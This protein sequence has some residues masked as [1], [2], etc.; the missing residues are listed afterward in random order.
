[1][2][3]IS[4]KAEANRSSAVSLLTRSGYFLREVF[5]VLS[6]SK[7]FAGDQGALSNANMRFQSFFM[8]ITIQ[9]SFLASSYKSWVKGLL[10]C[11]EAPRPV[12][13]RIRA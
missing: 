3:G 8:L 9:P 13:R 7:D 4:T 12:H 10:W 2:A 1:M 6:S 5:D 11:R